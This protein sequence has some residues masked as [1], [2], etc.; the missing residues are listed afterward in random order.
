[1]ALTGAD[2]NLKEKFIDLEIM[3]YLYHES[4]VLY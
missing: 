4:E 1:M 2:V 3:E